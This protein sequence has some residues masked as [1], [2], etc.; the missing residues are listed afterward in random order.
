[1]SFPMTWHRLTGPASLPF[2][3]T[4]APPGHATGHEGR[5]QFPTSSSEKSPQ[6]IPA[7]VSVRCCP[8]RAGGKCAPVWDVRARHYVEVLH[9]LVLHTLLLLEPCRQ[10]PTSTVRLAVAPLE[11]RLN[12]FGI[13]GGG[14]QIG[15]AACEVSHPNMPRSR[16]QNWAH[17]RFEKVSTSW[18]R[19]RS[20]N[21]ARP[22]NEK[23]SRSSPAERAA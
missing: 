6:T 20:Q 7:I 2:L 21:W 13:E 3:W 22:R 16:F 19:T 15:L 14:G 8:H 9:E 5:R 18:P 11:G 17:T 10:R 23:V 1:M 4:S 12:C